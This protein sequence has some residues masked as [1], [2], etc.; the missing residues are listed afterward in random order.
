MHRAANSDTPSTQPETQDTGTQQREKPQQ[1][2]LQA[3]AENAEEQQCTQPVSSSTSAKQATE[4][5]SPH[6]TVATPDK[7]QGESKANPPSLICPSASAQTAAGSAEPPCQ[8]Q[9][10][11]EDKQEILRKLSVAKARLNECRPYILSICKCSTT[12]LE[13]ALERVEP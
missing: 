13:F 9:L 8:Q 6:A 1:K 11:E 12:I 7:T 3:Q 2:E 4:T 5:V 10:S